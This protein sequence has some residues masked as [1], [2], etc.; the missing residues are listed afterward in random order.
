MFRMSKIHLVNPEHPVILSKTISAPGLPRLLL[1]RTGLPALQGGPGT[2]PTAHAH[3]LLFSRMPLTPVPGFV[4]R[5]PLA[6][7]ELS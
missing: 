5:V 6:A 3:D 2:L 4:L 7:L 1:T